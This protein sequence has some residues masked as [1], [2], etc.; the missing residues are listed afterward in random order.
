MTSFDVLSTDY[1]PK[2]WHKLLQTDLKQASLRL[3]DEKAIRDKVLS[4][5]SC[6]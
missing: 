5:P 1:Q 4:E 6:P 3:E 2:L